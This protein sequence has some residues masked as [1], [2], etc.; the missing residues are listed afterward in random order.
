MSPT[1]SIAV[2]VDGTEKLTTAKKKKRNRNP[3]NLRHD[4]RMQRFPPKL[5]N[6]VFPKSQR[7][8]E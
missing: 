4:I 7:K 8:G 3:Q 1:S 6:P 2:A 5:S